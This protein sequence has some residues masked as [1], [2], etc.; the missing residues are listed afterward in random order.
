MLRAENA[1]LKMRIEMDLLRAENA[2]LKR[3]Y[4]ML[5]GGKEME[6]VGLSLS[7]A[8]KVNWR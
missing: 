7:C 8:Y 2:E 4:E 1:A 5:S 3:K 6:K